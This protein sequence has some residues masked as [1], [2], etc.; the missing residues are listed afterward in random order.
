M[1]D[2]YGVVNPP[3][4]PPS[5]G[6]G[7][8]TSVSNIDG[9]ITVTGTATVAPVVSI[10]A[11]TVSTINGKAPLASPTFTGTPTA[12]TTPAGTNTT[13][14]ATTAFVE[15]ALAT[16]TIT[17]QSGTTYTFV[18]ADAMTEIEFTSASA[19]ALTIPTNAS[20][21][22]P[23]GTVINYRQQAAGRVTVA[24]AGGVTVH[25]SNGRIPAVW[26][27]TS[28]RVEAL[29]EPYHHRLANEVE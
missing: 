2:G 21:A 14:L 24:G 5:T 1:P 27:E 20:V 29:E 13:Q 15:T 4:S 28:E 8:V 10:S 25:S 7:T 22:F 11:T 19:V 23:I 26:I 6:T 18:L 16:V 9:T 12:P 3:Y 17:Q